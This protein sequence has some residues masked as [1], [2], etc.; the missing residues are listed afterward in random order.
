MPED[1]RPK[2]FVSPDTS[3][4]GYESALMDWDRLKSSELWAISTGDEFKA[5]VSLWGSSYR[6]SPPGSLPNNE[7]ILKKFSEAGDNWPN[8]R[9]V[10]L[11]G[12]VECSDGRLYHKVIAEDVLKAARNKQKR[13]RDMTP[14]NEALWRKRQREVAD[15]INGHSLNGHDTDKEHP[16]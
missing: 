1:G 15:Q 6:Q 8:V 5:A 16:L 3:I 7:R 12:F 2:P 11:H 9:E 4:D 14:A 13:S 10:A